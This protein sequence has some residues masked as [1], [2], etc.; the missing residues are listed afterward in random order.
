MKPISTIAGRVPSLRSKAALACDR[1]KPL[2]PARLREVM[3]PQPWTSKNLL[4]RSS[5]SSWGSKSDWETMR[6]A[7]E[8][9]NDLGVP[10][11][12]RIVSAHRTPELM[13]SSH[14]NAAGRGL[15]VIIAELEA[16]RTCQE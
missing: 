11:E 4:P 13:A 7:V 5:P 1:K 6:H 12:Y 10:H 16:P 3:E 9:L 8:L 2:Q 15:R 14:A